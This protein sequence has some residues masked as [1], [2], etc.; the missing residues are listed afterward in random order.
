[1]KSGFIVS[2]VNGASIAQNRRR[3]LTLAMIRKINQQM[4]IPLDILI[5]PIKQQR[6]S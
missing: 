2:R 6:V 4:G 1:M 3:G 5:Q